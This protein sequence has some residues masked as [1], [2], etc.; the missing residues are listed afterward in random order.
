MPASR[1]ELL[2]FPH[3]IPSSAAWP[4]IGDSSQGNGTTARRRPHRTTTHTH[5]TI[6]N[7]IDTV[8]GKRRYALVFFGHGTRRLGRAHNQNGGPREMVASI[9]TAMSVVSGLGLL[10]LMALSSAFIETL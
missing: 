6:K 2:V 1:A 7:L 5:T 9:S 10:A 4:G 8:L 3:E